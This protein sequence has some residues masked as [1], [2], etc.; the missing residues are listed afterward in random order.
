[1]TPTRKEAVIPLFLLTLFQTILQKT[2][3]F[4]SCTSH[5]VPAAT[6]QN[7]LKCSKTFS[8]LFKTQTEKLKTQFSYKHLFRSYCITYVFQ[9][10]L[11]RGLY[12]RFV[13]EIVVL[14]NRLEKK[15]VLLKTIFEPSSNVIMSNKNNIF[16]VNISDFFK[17]SS[18]NLGK[19]KAFSRP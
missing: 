16:E 9:N 7:I 17:I 1:M 12:D 18:I 10:N 2:Y 6:T 13:Y 14:L 5:V 3:V 8:K 15:S 11:D 4:I 19:F